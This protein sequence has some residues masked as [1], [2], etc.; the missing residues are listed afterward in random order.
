MSRPDRSVH[1]N[2]WTC[3]WFPDCNVPCKKPCENPE[4]I[5]RRCAAFG[6]HKL[7]FCAH[8]KWGFY[9]SPE[10]DIHTWESISRLKSNPNGCTKIYLL[11]YNQDKQ[12]I[13]FDLSRNGKYNLPSY[14]RLTSQPTDLYE[15]ASNYFFS[16]FPSN[17]KVD[18][19]PFVQRRFIFH[20]SSAIYPVCLNNEFASQI[21]SKLGRKWF[22]REEIEREVKFIKIQWTL[23]PD[24]KTYSYKVK[25]NQAILGGRPLFPLAA[26]VFRWLMPKIDSESA[27]SSRARS[28]VDSAYST[29]YTAASSGTSGYS[30]MA[31]SISNVEIIQD[32]DFRTSFDEFIGDYERQDLSIKNVRLKENLIL[33]YDVENIDRKIFSDYQIEIFNNPFQFISRIL[34]LTDKTVYLIISMNKHRLIIPLI[35]KHFCVEKIYL[36]NQ[37]IITDFS[38]ISEKID[39]CYADFNELS[40]QMINDIKINDNKFQDKNLF[41]MLHTQQLTNQYSI[42]STR[43]N[44][45]HKQYVVIFDDET[46]EISRSYRETISFY[47]SSNFQECI[48]FIRDHRQLQILFILS[49]TFIVEEVQS[50]CD[51]QQTI[52]LYFLKPNFSI[53][54]RKVKGIFN[55]LEELFVELH[56]DI[57]FYQEGDFHTSNISI[58][59][60]INREKPLIIQLNEKQ[61]DFL[62]FSLFLDILPYIPSLNFTEED[63][64]NLCEML[65][66]TQETNI[67][68]YIVQIEQTNNLIRFIE[69]P[70]CS[71]TINQLHKFN[72]LLIF[73]HTF[74]SIY[75]QV[76]QSNKSVI[77]D[78]VYM[79]KI[80]TSEALN[81][82]Q[83]NHCEYIHIGIF[84]LATKSLLTARSIARTMVNN[85]LIAVLF[86]I[87]LVEQI[88]FLDIDN[89]RILFSPNTLF[90]LKSINKACDDVFYIR[91]KPVQTEYQLF[92]EQLHIEL[93]FQLCWL[94]YGNYLYYFNRF[95]QGELY[96]NYLLEKILDE[97][98]SRA[99]ISNNLGLLYLNKCDDGNKQEYFDKAQRILKE[100]L[101][102]KPKS[103]IE[104]TFLQED[105]HYSL[106]NPVRNV[107]DY[108]TVVGTIADSY[109]NTN[110]YEEALKFYL[111]ALEL[112]VNPQNCFYYR[113]MIFKIKNSSQIKH[114]SHRDF[115]LKSNR[116]HIFIGIWLYDDYFPSDQQNQMEIHLNR[117]FHYYQAFN[118]LEK[119]SSYFG[120]DRVL[121]VAKIFFIISI[122]DVASNTLVQLSEEYSNTE[123]FYLF[124]TSG[125]FSSVHFMTNSMESLF[126]QMRKDIRESVKGNNNPVKKNEENKIEKPFYISRVN[127]I[128]TFIEKFIT[129]SDEIRLNTHGIDDSIKLCKFLTIINILL[130]NVL[131]LFILPTLQHIRRLE[132]SYL[133]L[134]LPLSNYWIIKRVNEA[135]RQDLCLLDQNGLVTR[136]NIHESENIIGMR[137]FGKQYFLVLRQIE[138]SSLQ[139]QWFHIDK[140]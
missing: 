65:F 112:S 76:S 120:R 49:N 39:G 87:D 104:R 113:K 66:D 48:Q 25:N 118:S 5:H 117:L 12:Q 21:L 94:T 14:H 129:K 17:N 115:T 85:G 96:F 107:I 6:L 123:K 15:V 139:M 43:K 42:I 30:S 131:D 136:L 124:L 34:S 47:Q 135:N 16:L 86:Q 132:N 23:T 93:D 18:S 4:H 22:D 2:E 77:F 134:Y 72:E 45:L 28:P 83:S 26:F 103:V 36:Y 61:I 50:I 128:S 57:L 122:S 98:S 19:F 46:H 69:D 81:S 95:Q 78:S 109:F 75:R 111:K 37:Q 41:C 55:T 125:S 27:A 58:F 71:K 99:A 59:T 90:Q 82:L 67:S 33:C 52:L 108:P 29:A 102:R 68:D 126:E 24:N 74:F 114:F 54:H 11:I 3:Y 56:K 31:P 10:G 105:R 106:V 63:L 140:F 97:N 79:S 138:N 121:H 133:V 62:S 1:D 53:H 40:N 116:D 9:Y 92:K 127:Q 100:N 110:Q 84:I 64:K 130:L 38:S 44:S 137:F 88:N 51:S 73:Q 20:N 89:E 60:K 13:L 70:N 101:F 119:L 80:I 35:H 91:I 7:N 32:P 8:G